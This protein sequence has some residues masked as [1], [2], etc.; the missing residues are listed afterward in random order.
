MLESRSSKTITAQEFYRLATDICD[1]F[2]KESVVVY[3][4][5][6]KSSAQGTGKKNASGKLYESY[7]S[8]RRKLRQSGYLPNT[9]RSSSKT[10]SV[11]SDDNPVSSPTT[12]EDTDEG[13]K[14]I[15]MLF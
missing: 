12:T 9:S 2:P 10:S 14:F 7:I 3:Y 6:Y 15:T 1:I 8:R 5:A 4:S 13:E 11:P